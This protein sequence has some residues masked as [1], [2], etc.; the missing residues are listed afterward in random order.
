[1]RF[2][3]AHMANAAQGIY[4]VALPQDRNGNYVISR[5]DQWIEPLNAWKRHMAMREVTTNIADVS[6]RKENWDGYGSAAPNEQ[7]V[8]RAVGIISSFYT[9]AI[10]RRTGWVNPFVGLSER[11]DVVFEWW[12]DQKK[13]SLYVGPDTTDYVSSW[14]PH[15]EE[16]MDA[17][18]ADSSRF[19]DLW[20]WLTTKSA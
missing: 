20:T 12:N 11:G 5:R 15:I 8:M 7:A 9:E 3:P 19:G 2:T 14:G 13:L 4:E 10:Q 17:G 18:A 16:Q 1:M 6:A